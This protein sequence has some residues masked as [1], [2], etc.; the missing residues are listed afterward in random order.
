MRLRLGALVLIL[1]ALGSC[2][3][4]LWMVLTAFR[5]RT[6]ITASPPQ[7]AFHWTLENFSLIYNG[8]PILDLLRNSLVVSG[9]TVAL[10]LLIGTP[11]AYYFARERSPWTKNLFLFVLATR[12]APPV[13]LSLPMFV[14][15]TEVGLRGTYLAVIITEAIF[16]IAFVVWFLEASITNIPREAEMAAQVDGRTRFGAIASV[17]LPPLTPALAATAAFVFLFSWNEY[18][19][20]SLLSSSST[21]PV[22]PALPGFIAQATSQW[23]AFCAVAFLSSIPPLILAVFVRR[24]FTRAFTVGIISDA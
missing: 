1:L 5:P 23:G 4:Y 17:V 18:M 8:Q 6:V 19:I 14:L 21:R 7:F 11:A 2:L 15:F 9:G 13:A 3:P 24:F 10:S 16:N 20:A 22:T 12:M